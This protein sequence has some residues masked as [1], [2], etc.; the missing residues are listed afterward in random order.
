MEFLVTVKDKVNLDRDIVL[1]IDP[2]QSVR[3]LVVALSDHFG[4]P[5]NSLDLERTRQSL[6]LDAPIK[7][8]GVLSGDVLLA[9]GDPEPGLPQVDR[10]RTL[11]FVVGPEAGRY[12]A[13]I[14]GSSYEV[15]SANGL[16]VVVADESVA[17]HHF[18]IDVASDYSAMVT[19]LGGTV[20]V[21]GS[22]ISNP[23][24]V[25]PQDFIEAGQLGFAVREYFRV[26]DR[27]DRLGQVEFHRT[28]YRPQLI[29]QRE[30]PLFGPIPAT[31]PQNRFQFLALLAPIFFGLTLFLTQGR[32]ISY[33]LFI[34]LS[35]LLLIA[36]YVDDKRRGRKTRKETRHDF[37]NMLSE[38]VVVLRN[39]VEQERR[40]RWQAAPDT[41]SL[42]RRAEFRT[43]DLW[44]RS[45][46]SPDFLS[47]RFG[48]FDAPSKVSSPLDR[49]GDDDLRDQALKEFAF[50]TIVRDVPYVA[51][52]GEL[53]AVAVSGD[54]GLAVSFVS[55]LLMQIAALHS[56]E[57]L[58]IMV[59]ARTLE[60]DLRTEQ[61][62]LAETTKW[63]PHTWS[64]SSPLAGSHVCAE[65]GDLDRLLGSII[66][67]ADNRLA[68]DSTSTKRRWPWM[69]VVIDSAL[70]P[71][72]TQVAQL[73]DRCP[74]A[75]ISVIWLATARTDIPRQVVSIVEVGEGKGSHNSIVWSTDPTVPQQMIQL[76]TVSSSTFR[77]F[78]RALAPLRDASEAQAA[79]SIPRTAPLLDVLGVDKATGPWILERWGKQK[80]Y[81]LAHPIGFDV[82]GPFI[83]DLVA[84]GPHALIGGTSGAG[85]SELLQSMVA[86]LISLYS[87]QR[88]NLL[89][90]DYKGGATSNAFRR[91]PHAVG[92][93][94][95][96]NEDL[97][98]RALVSL[99][100]ELNR[101][102]RLITED[103]NCKDLREMLERNPNQAPP[104]LVIIVD[105]FATLVKEI[106]VFVPEIVTISQQGRSLG[107]HL[108]LATQRP[109]GAVSD[110]ILA[111]TNLRL[112][113][114]M[115]DS[116]ESTA[117]IGAPDAADIPVPLKGRGYARMGYRE[118]TPFQAAYSGALLVSAQRKA[119]VSVTDFEV[120]NSEDLEIG[121]VSPVKPD[122]KTHLDN[123]IEAVCAAAESAGLPHSRSVW[124]DDLPE[125][126][127]FDDLKIDGENFGSSRHVG[128]NIVIGLVDDPEQQNQYPGS[129]DLET[130]GGLLVFGSGGAGKTTLLRTLTYAAATKSTP[131]E[132]QFFIFDF[133]AKGLQSL[134]VLPHV[135][136][137]ANGDDLEAVTRL[138]SVL[139][140]EIDERRQLLAVSQ[141]E[142][143]TAH[144]AKG[145]EL[146]RIVVVV[147]EYH[148]F[149][150]SMSSSVN[151]THGEIWIDQLTRILINGRSVGVHVVLTADRRAAIPSNIHAAVSARIVLRQSDDL[152]YSDFGLS[153]MRSRNVEL[154]PG[155]G[156][157][158][159]DKRVQVACVSSQGESS[160]QAATI[161][162]TATRMTFSNRSTIKTARLP[163]LI[164]WSNENILKDEFTFHIGILDITGHPASVNLSRSHLLISGP[165]MS[166]RSNALRIFAEQISDQTRLWVVGSSLSPLSELKTK[167]SAFGK[168]KQVQH[169]L[170]ELVEQAESET[171]QYLVIDDLDTYGEGGVED[172]WTTIANAENIRVIATIETRNLTSFSGN[173]LLRELRHSR[174]Q[175]LLQPENH[176][177]LAQQ[178]GQ[179][180]PVRPG[181]EFPQGRAIILSDRNIYCAQ[182]PFINNKSEKKLN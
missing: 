54:H 154:P 15:G 16:S 50:S 46:I 145:H 97:A 18:Q 36:N 57:D 131:E 78:V 63:L 93:V 107:I 47:V 153:N 182:I 143:L 29:Q 165:P 181:L 8:V 167:H 94:T 88:L 177:E 166:G 99:K 80:Q 158:V 4:Q 162:N 23:T 163:D 28:P 53:G 32:Q 41:P 95:N 55:S 138:I 148:N 48:L 174:T 134:A 161:V 133:G 120:G 126:V 83:I 24:I 13:L 74:S 70:K 71:N 136:G 75:G 144:L 112:S 113:L 89:F 11:D 25:E 127:T 122:E 108:I 128:R 21:N 3:D 79:A 9:N 61:I 87:P 43:S 85:K 58:V 123:I 39:A 101:R 20:R 40:E 84:H 110:N 52:L 35:P 125:H 45:R 76:G 102:Q 164:N 150:A 59:G 114:R 69:V 5:I 147:D 175:L 129:V 156:F 155:R 140:A 91:V 62:D 7:K 141:S 6:S 10:A 149:V 105:E 178:L 33:L 90:I 179:R 82:N 92:H 137:F 119:T 86:S 157:W 109:S 151:F 66:A 173:E 180:I 139:Q 72:P 77:S 160:E 60:L 42:R 64:L 132:V 172:L 31:S 34:L 68:G 96:L 152:S 19:P 44:P 142:T 14:S 100:A 117:V 49:G 65:K 135:T 169:L 159:N 12:V 67:I 56:P 130:G 17:E 118:L 106:P 98:L 121:T 104:S 111:N 37:T 2:G 146:P 1:D 170:E 73:L 51:S 30:F 124:K 115:L 103:H 26:E 38:R 176:M 22:E 27:I 171:V 81:G 168:L 116:S